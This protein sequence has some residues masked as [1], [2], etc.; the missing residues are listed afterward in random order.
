MKTTE[1]K[2]ARIRTTE[3]QYMRGGPA[4]HIDQGR[5][6]RFPARVLLRPEGTYQK[7]QVQIKVLC[8][9]ISVVPLLCKI[10][11]TLLHTR[12]INFDI[13]LHINHKTR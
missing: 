6:S 5:R 11:L 3:K 1:N 4:S 10:Q 8:M 13:C 12:F 7:M 9:Y 2:R